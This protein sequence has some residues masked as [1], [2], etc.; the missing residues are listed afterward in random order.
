[1]RVANK[2]IAFRSGSQAYQ[3]MVL[4]VLCTQTDTQ[5]RVNVSS[6]TVRGKLHVGSEPT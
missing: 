6:E 1:M 5:A 3:N 4:W 2:T